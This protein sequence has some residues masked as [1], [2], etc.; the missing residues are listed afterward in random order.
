MGIFA[1]PQHSGGIVTEAL[2]SAKLKIFTTWPFMGKSLPVPKLAHDIQA[3]RSELREFRN[4]GTTG[5]LDSRKRL[6]FRLPPSHQIYSSSSV[7]L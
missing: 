6:A 3:G 2:W 4:Q 1:P 5:N 7:F